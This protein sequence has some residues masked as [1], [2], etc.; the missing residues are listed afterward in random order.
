MNKFKKITAVFLFFALLI[1]LFPCNIHAENDSIQK[2]MNITSNSAILMDANSGKIL[3][4]KNKDTPYPPASVTKIMTLL[5]IME[6]IE[7]GKFSLSDTVYAS[8]HACSMGGSQIYLKEGEGMSVEDLLKSVVISS[9]NDAALALAEFASGSEEAFV[10][11]MNEKA[12]S[13]NMKNTN[14]ENT[15]GLDDTSKNHTSSAYDIAVMS[16]ELIKHKDIQKYSST[17]QDSIRNGE[18]ILTNTNKLV[19]F[20][21]GCT[22]LKTGS[23]SK[24]GFCISVTASRDGVD[25]ICV[26]MGAESSEVRNREAASLLDFGFASYK[27]YTYKS[28][29]FENIKIYCG[30]EDFISAHHDEFRIL[31]KKEDIGKVMC[32][33]EM[34]EDIKAPVN[35]GD[36]IGKVV[37]YLNDEK[38]GEKDIISDV[39]IEKITFFEMFKRIFVLSQRL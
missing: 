31:L 35:K 13:L 22:G 8:K 10:K 32:K 36:T 39:T 5:L 27:N 19:R 28:G 14:F 33:I 4:E 38:I 1:S 9:A 3:Y 25:L 11:R 21:K 17:W 6:D 23:T 30:K 16:R 7:S 24:A 26:I 37:F 20:Y 18:F 2:N 12:V 15:N 34:N 29:N